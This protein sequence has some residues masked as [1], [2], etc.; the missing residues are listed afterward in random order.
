MLSKQEAAKAVLA[1]K[2]RLG[3]TWSQIA[4]ALG[5]PVAWTTAALLGQ[6]PIPPDI[7]AKLLE[8]LSLDDAAVPVL[9]AVP[10]RGGFSAAV[11]TD[12]TIYRFYEALSVYGGAMLRGHSRYSF[13]TLISTAAGR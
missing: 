8:M 6:H 1:A 10:M 5:R 3:L 11:P 9:A 12:P 4:G 7:G 13:T 2:V